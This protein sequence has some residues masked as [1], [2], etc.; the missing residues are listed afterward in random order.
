[1]GAGAGLTLEAWLNPSVITG[2][3][4]L[5]EWNDGK[6]NIGASVAL[7]GSAFEASFTD[8]NALPVRRVIFRS[9]PGILA[10][11]VW[12]HVALTFNKAAGQAAIYVDGKVVA[13]TNLTAFRPATR[14]PLYLG[15]RPS[16]TNAVAYYVGLLDE[17]TLY[18]RA[19]TPAE[20]QAIVAA[21][22]AGKCVPPPPLPVPPPAGIVGW[23]RGE[24]NTL[25]S[26]DSN[27][28]IIVPQVSYTNGVSGKAFRFDTGYVRIPATSNLNVGTGPGFTI[29]AW[30]MPES[31]INLFG[32]GSSEVVGWHSGTVTRGVSLS[33]GR[34]SK[35]PPFP[36]VPTTSQVWEA[37]VA[38]TQG[39]SHIIRSPADLATFDAW[40]HVALTY[41]KATGTAVLYFN[42]NPV[43]QTNLGSFTPQTAA[44]LNL[45]YQI[46][47]PIPER[48]PSGA[49]DE[50]SLY[51][52]AL[53][54]AE[55]R[56]IMLSRGTG[57][58][59]DPPVILSNPANV[60]ANAGST[61]IFTVSASGNPILKYQWRLN[62][63]AASRCDRR[64]PCPD[65]SPDLPGRHLFRPR[66]QC[67]RCCSQLQRAAHR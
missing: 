54:A 19:L 27:N 56:A 34:I 59:K 39:R 9:A 11:S 62:G 53:S 64:D 52:R 36:P 13:Q 2:V 28:G 12:H 29:E 46:P 32:Y 43:T 55:I 50:V 22:S 8:T 10:T 38:D 14:A 7:T 61:A 30:I 51:A 37:D 57:K 5:V 35:A 49:L 23:W 6:G 67:L 40:Q 16:G 4:P 58:S 3:Q 1:M 21:G 63:V 18:D 26:V 41:D 17:L 42:G 31:V 20:L 47:S 24:S 15:S 48:F 44:D 45:G 66:H 60:Q 25:D 33:F 65:Q